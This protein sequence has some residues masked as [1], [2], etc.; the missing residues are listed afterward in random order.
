MTGFTKILDEALSREEIFRKALF[1]R[2][3]SLSSLLPYD[4]VLEKENIFLK[5]I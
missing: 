4:E 2:P 3:E 5:T 1:E